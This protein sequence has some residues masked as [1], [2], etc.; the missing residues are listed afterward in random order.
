ML[1]AGENGN[2]AAAINLSSQ[3]TSLHYRLSPAQ[4]NHLSQTFSFPLNDFKLN[5]RVAQHCSTG[6]GAGGSAGL[7]QPSPMQT[8]F[9]GLELASPRP[10]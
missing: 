8:G 4:G 7:R 3:T 2:T 6:L 9:V 1:L 10:G 5:L